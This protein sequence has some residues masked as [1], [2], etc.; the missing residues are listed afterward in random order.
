[1]GEGV[2]DR[3]VLFVDGN[4]WYH[5]L[6]NAGVT[7]RLHLDYVKIAAKLVGPRT[8]LGTRYYVGKVSQRGN[9]RLYAD[10]RRF[11]AL[12]TQSDARHTFHYGRLEPRTVES[13]AAKVL[14]RYLHNLTTRIDGTVFK[15]LMEIAKAH[16]KTT[17][18]AE[19]AVDV[20]LAVDLV[21]MA[22]RDEYDTAY[23]L[24]A[25]GDFTPAVAAA[26]GLGK[27]VFAVSPDHGHQLA[28]AV[29]SFIHIKADWFIGCR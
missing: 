6:V 15:E 28:G 9:V 17:V 26:R 23:L 14:E 13:E 27:K 22:Q 16:R 8:W 24:S 2:P 18:M 7:G 3:A 4:N 29:D 1:M 21:T 25:D 12:F 19:K 10:Q 20:N 5:S 11:E